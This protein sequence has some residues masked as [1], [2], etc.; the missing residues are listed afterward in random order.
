M[1][2]TR[3]GVRSWI[4]KSK[5]TTLTCSPAQQPHKYNGAVTFDK[6][7]TWLSNILRSLSYE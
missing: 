5:A 6:T 7:S 4:Y 1:L 3:V 2:Q